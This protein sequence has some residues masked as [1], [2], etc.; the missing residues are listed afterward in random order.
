MNPKVLIG[1]FP[2]SGTSFLCNLIVEMG[3][4]PGKMENLKPADKDN[5]NGYWEYLPI[6]NLTWQAAFRHPKGGRKFSRIFDPQVVGTPSTVRTSLTAM[7]IPQVR[8]KASSWCCLQEARCLSARSAPSRASSS[9]TA[10][11]A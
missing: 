6:R 11:N 2:R 5:P 7:G 9:V 3:F 8:G 10:R 1:G 4:S